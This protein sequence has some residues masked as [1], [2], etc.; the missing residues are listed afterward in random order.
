MFEKEIFSPEKLEK[1]AK[2]A[3][4]MQRQEQIRSGDLIPYSVPGPEEFDHLYVKGGKKTSSKK[5]VKAQPEGVSSGLQTNSRSWDVDAN[6]KPYKIQVSKKE[7]KK[8]EDYKKSRP[9]LYN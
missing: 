6:G 7:K 5:T 2:E 8:I 3:E 1:M 4:L 9:D